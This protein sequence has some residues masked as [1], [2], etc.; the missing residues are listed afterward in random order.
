MKNI[1]GALLLAVSVSAFAG[2]VTG[3]AVDSASPSIDNQCEKSSNSD[4]YSSSGHDGQPWLQLVF[5]PSSL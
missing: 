2:S 1:L 4:H 3:N 5:T